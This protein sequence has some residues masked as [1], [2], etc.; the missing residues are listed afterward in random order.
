MVNLE[1]TTLFLKSA[2]LCGWN[3]YEIGKFVSSATATTT[4]GS[5]NLPYNKAS[6][7]SAP[8][9][10]LEKLVQ[11][12]RNGEGKFQMEEFKKILERFFSGNG[13]KNNH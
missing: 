8:G 1:I 13:G 4:A 12:G 9:G 3:L 6:G 11:E 5:G 10:S 2:A 7:S